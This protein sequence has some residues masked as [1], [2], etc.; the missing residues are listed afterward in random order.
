[1]TIGID[2]PAHEQTRACHPDVEG[3]VE[4]KGL[5]LRREAK[6]PAGGPAGRGAS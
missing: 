2:A 1:M 4:R 6:R 3:Y 5:P